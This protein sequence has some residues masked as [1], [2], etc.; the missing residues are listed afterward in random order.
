VTSGPARSQR[1][2]LLAFGG[3]MLA[4]LLAALDQ[5]IVATALPR[6]VGDLRGFNH[7]SW[8]VTA[9]LVA[10][11]VTI[12]LY[13]KLSDVY[14]RRRM[15]VV[16]IV[17]FVAG[18]ALCGM[19]RSMNELIAFRALQGLGAGGL[20]PLSQAAVA[21]L[22]S[23]RE[24][25]RYQG[26][27]GAAWAT[28]SIAGPLVGGT[29]TD[30]ASWR[31]IFLI[32][33]PLGALALFVVVRTMPAVRRVRDHR[34][35]YA[36]AAL[37]S[38]GVTGVLLASVWG[39]TTYPWGSPEV[40]GVGVGG[41]AL[42]AAFLWLERRVPEPLLSLDLFR[43]RVV[44]VASAATFVVGAVLFGV[45][46]YV[47]VF[48]QGVLGGS[49]TSSGVILIPLSLGW[50]A[51]S[52]LSGQIVARTG[53]YRVFPIVGST[54]VLAGAA[55]LSLLDASSSRVAVAA[56]LVV[57]GI[58]MG[59]MV[60]VYVLAAQNAVS[61]S[62]IGITTATLQF[63]RAMGGS[64][65]VA[66][67]GA[68]LT[69]RVVD[70]L[71]RRLGADAGRVDADRLLQGSARVPADLLHG[72]REALAVALHS[73]FLVAVPLAAVGLAIAFALTELPLRRSAPPVEVSERSPSAA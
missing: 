37:L 12:P 72:T 48:V 52:I 55:L 27:I 68:L 13:G 2:L 58:G 18:S 39:G 34:I 61:A 53:R 66:G 8:I 47:P 10:S 15:F 11:T 23:P 38:A 65:A 57:V 4:T 70:E 67:L 56:A 40:L 36:G 19:A 43:N 45:T 42:I 64:L 9:Y 59:T 24:R 30:A 50:V 71:G 41:A 35:D 69:N 49:A 63:F 25:G 6:I 26:F 46:I 20:I 29:L 5:T 44:S 60:Q 3:I 32:N 17:I 31:W 22:F 14:G 33:L 28:A 21:D 16:A 1:E 7:L 73:V 62:L 54:L 51:A